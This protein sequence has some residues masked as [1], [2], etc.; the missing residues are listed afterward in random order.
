[1]DKCEGPGATCEEVKQDTCFRT[2]DKKQ[3][4][5][6]VL[7]VL[8]EFKQHVEHRVCLKEREGTWLAQLIECVTPDLSVVT[9]SP[10]LG[11]RE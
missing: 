5:V 7:R 1:M 2:G 11:V 3:T 6:L 9:S 4:G 8:P 10:T